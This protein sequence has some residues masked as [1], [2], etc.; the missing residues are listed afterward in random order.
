VRAPGGRDPTSGAAPSPAHLAAQAS[1]L[2]RGRDIAHGY[3]RI[4]GKVQDLTDIDSSIND[5]GRIGY[6]LGLER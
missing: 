2:S 4:G 1:E 5:H 3:Q 6:G